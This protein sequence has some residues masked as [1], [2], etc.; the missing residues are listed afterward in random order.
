M[1]TV[2]KGCQ[3]RLLRGGLW[4]CQR[5]CGVLRRDCSSGVI[6]NGNIHWTVDRGDRG[7]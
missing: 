6:F 7:C 2:G 1:M 3:V 4:L 5:I